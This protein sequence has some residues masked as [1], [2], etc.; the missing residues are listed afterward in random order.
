[1]LG[2]GSPVCLSR[3]PEERWE[4]TRS[5]ALVP[6]YPPLRLGTLRLAV[7]REGEAETLLWSRTG[8]H[9]N[10]WHEAWAT[11][12]HQLGSGTKYQVRPHAWGAGAGKAP[13]C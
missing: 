6:S 12:H 11:L 13:S 10:R 2:G 4:A 8:T 5:G 1:M 9:G 7:R 3:A